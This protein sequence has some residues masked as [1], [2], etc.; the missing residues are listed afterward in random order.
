[1]SVEVLRWLEEQNSMAGCSQRVGLKMK[2][3]DGVPVTAG[4]TA[5]SVPFTPPLPGTEIEAKSSRG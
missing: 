4:E 1:M 5:W 2:K 3:K